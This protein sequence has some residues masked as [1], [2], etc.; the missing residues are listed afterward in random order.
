MYSQLL[1]S[2]AAEHAGDLRREA[3]ASSL[4][5]RAR[6]ARPR[7]RGHHVGR[8]AHAHGPDVRLMPRAA[9]S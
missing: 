9:R 7:H 4:A 8:R 1:P 5:R 6:P 3:K 2:M